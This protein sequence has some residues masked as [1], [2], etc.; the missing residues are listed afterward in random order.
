MYSDSHHP[1]RL[2]FSGFI[3]WRGT[4]PTPMRLIE[5][6]SELQRHRI[7]PGKPWLLYE[8]QQQFQANEFPQ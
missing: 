3:G 5:A 2:P 7:R 6:P 1:F 8:W 4:C